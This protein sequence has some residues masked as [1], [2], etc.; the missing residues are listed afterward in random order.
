[1]PLGTRHTD[2]GILQPG[3]WGYALHRDDGGIWQLDCA[4]RYNSLI[5]QRV[6]V[7]GTRGGFN[8]LDA[9]RIWLYGTTPP[10][11]RHPFMRLFRGVALLSD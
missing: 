1:M 5:G 3:I 10:R 9:D 6:T 2:T 8:I 11:P 7:E 4:R